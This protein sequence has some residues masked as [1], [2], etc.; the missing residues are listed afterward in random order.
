M[1]YDGLLALVQRRRSV[2]RFRPDS[3]PDEYIE[4]IIEV[5]RRAPSGFSMQPWEFFVVREPG[6]RKL[7]GG[8]PILQGQQAPY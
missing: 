1:D 2:R 3:V 8:A 4:R 5:A 7:L 6:L